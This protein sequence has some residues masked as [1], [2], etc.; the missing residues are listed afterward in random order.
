MAFGSGFIGLA[1]FRKVCGVAN[2]YILCSPSHF[3]IRTHVHSSHPV[4]RIL[5]PLF[6]H[7]RHQAGRD[8]A[9]TPVTASL[10]WSV[11]WSRSTRSKAASPP[12]SAVFQ[13]IPPLCFSATTFASTPSA[14]LAARIFFSDTSTTG[15]DSSLFSADHSFGLP[16]TDRGSGTLE[17]VCSSMSQTY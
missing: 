13:A 12:C 2:P 1:R 14:R 17:T 10:I 7:H 3:L 6:A 15:V 9:V 5:S 11:A 4:P 16:L 8:I